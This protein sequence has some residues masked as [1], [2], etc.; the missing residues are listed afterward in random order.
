MQRAIPASVRSAI[1]FDGDDTLWNTESLYDHARSEAARVVAGEGYDPNE[2][3]TLQRAIDARSVDTM[4]LSVD[5][6][7]TSSVEAF[8]HL[9]R[10]A[11]ASPDPRAVERVRTASASVFEAKAALLPFAEEVLAELHRSFRL[12]LL[13]KGEE[14][15][16][17]R[18]IDDSGLGS[19]FESIEV[20]ADKD[21]SAF[22]RLLA[23]MGTSPRLSWSIGNSLPSDVAPAIAAGMQAI[24]IDAPVWEHERREHGIEMTNPRLHIATSLD[25]VPAIIASSTNSAS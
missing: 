17:R 13:T 3:E 14:H 8:M 12:A 1:I 19:Y 6:F 20:V 4:G 10:R 9:A 11:G 16:Q 22:T 23:R 5:R 15:I 25:G 7:P 18:R 24:W 2:F 21:V